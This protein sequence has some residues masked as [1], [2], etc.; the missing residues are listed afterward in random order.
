VCFARYLYRHKQHEP[1]FDCTVGRK[2]VFGLAHHYMRGSQFSHNSRQ[3]SS[4]FHCLSFLLLLQI[5]RHRVL[6]KMRY[7]K[8]T[9]ENNVNCFIPFMTHSRLL[10]CLPD[11][12]LE[13]CLAAASSVLNRL[14]LFNPS[15]KPDAICH[16]RRLMD[17]H[18]ERMAARGVKVKLLSLPL[19]NNSPPPH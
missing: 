19:V 10:S 5:L 3:S 13:A 1:I 8:L 6:L 14:S 18:R 7:H 11:R 4:L 9:W 2:C 15:V 17:M 12:P 16:G